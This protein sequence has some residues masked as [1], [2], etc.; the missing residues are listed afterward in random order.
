[1]NQQ[2]TPIRAFIA[3]ELPEAVKQELSSLQ[4]RLGVEPATGIKWVAPEGIHLTLKFL[5][6]VA[7][8]RVETIKA[9]L[10][11]SMAGFEPF[12]LKLSGLGAFPNFRRMNVIWCGLSG[13]LARLAALQQSVEKFVSPLGFPT[14]KRAFSPHLTLARLRDEVTP[15]TKLKLSE[16][17]TRNK[18][19][20]NLPI[21][22]ESVHL[23]QSQLFPT[24]AAYTSLGSFPLRS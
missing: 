17:L 6:W 24:G 10:A 11:D 2:A 13:D 14:E 23:M 7:P 16:K 4:R 21:P 20:P 3:I 8:D 22:V 1:M 12:E 15:E 19:E 5:G 9:A 18:F